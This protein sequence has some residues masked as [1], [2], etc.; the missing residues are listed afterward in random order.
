[1]KA[2]LLALALLAAAAQAQTVPTSRYDE[3]YRYLA[4]P[5]RRTDPFDPLKYIRL[6]AGGSLTLGGELRERWEGVSNPGFA[7]GRRPGTPT[8]N[9]YLLQRALLHADLHLNENIR[10][11]VQ[12]GSYSAFGARGNS[13]GATQRNDVDLAQAFFDVSLG[14]GEAGRL[15]LRGGRQELSLGSSRLVSE[16]EGPNLRRAFDGGRAFLQ[17]AGGLR[18]DTF[19]LRPVQPFHGPF[20]DRGSSAETL[21]GGYAT[22][23]VRPGV[24]L[25]LYHL[26]YQRARASFAQGQGFEKRQTIGGRFFGRQSGWDWD[27]EAAFQFGAFA[28]SQVRAWTVA[29]D[30]GFTFGDL[31]GRPRIGLKADIASGDGNPRNHTL[32]TFNALYPKVPYF[33]EAGLVAPA[34]LID[35]SPSLRLQPTPELTLELGWDVLWR[36]R[37]A[38]AFY[39]PVPFAPLRG[40]AGLANPYIGHQTQLSA[41]WMVNRHV[42]LRAWFVHF[43]AGSTITRAGGRDVDF[44]AASVALRF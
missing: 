9:N 38:D 34:N 1:M 25:D 33:T 13:L 41:R 18:V 43:A 21:W 12:L 2:R 16:R 11:F 5:A 24:G 14:L 39:R 30:T 42:E 20:D 17:M 40:T 32:G 44:A 37:T 27:A 4:D 10:G 3:D 22:T 29:S 36:Q 35:V 15:T 23:P 6:G 26:G 28:N 19:L 8:V 31:P 7:I